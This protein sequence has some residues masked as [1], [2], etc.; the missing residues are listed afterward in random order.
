MLSPAL[1]GMLLWVHLLETCTAVCAHLTAGVV[2][3]FQPELLI[4]LPL[5]AVL[6]AP[7]WLPI[8]LLLIVF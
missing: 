1:L 8:L 2:I 3:A 6:T 7:V 4:I 5:L